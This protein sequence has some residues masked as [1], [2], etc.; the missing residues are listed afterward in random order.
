MRYNEFFLFH[1]ISLHSPSVFARRPQRISETGTYIYLLYQIYG[2]VREK[3][4]IK[5]KV[6]IEHMFNWIRI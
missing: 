4:L 1:K 3:M 6:F 5:Q 2:S